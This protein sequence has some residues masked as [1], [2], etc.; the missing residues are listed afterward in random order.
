LPNPLLSLHTT[1]DNL[2]KG[3]YLALET[4]VYDHP[5]DK[6]ICYFMHMQNND[7]SNFWAL[8]TYVLKKYLQLLG[9]VEIQE[10]LKVAP[11]MLEKHMSR[12]ILVAKK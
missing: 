8:S 2:K 7:P 3:G 10:L 9:F 4:Q 6:N 11:K 1:Y 5:G 12:I